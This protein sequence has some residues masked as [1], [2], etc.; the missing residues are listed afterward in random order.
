[1]MVLRQLNLIPDKEFSRHKELDIYMQVWQAPGKIANI[2]AI[3]SYLKNQNIPGEIIE[4]QSISEKLIKSQP[5]L[6][7]KYENEIKP[8]KISAFKVDILGDTDHLIFFVANSRM[9]LHA[10]IIRRNQYKYTLTDPDTLKTIEGPSLSDLLQ[11]VRKLEPSY[12]YTGISI[13]ISAQ[14]R[15]EQILSQSAS[16]TLFS[17]SAQDTTEQNAPAKIIKPESNTP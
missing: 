14:V 10:L 3:L 11:S 8:Q 6:K 1:M 7:Q 12:I 13:K 4:D 16:Q 5:T 17:S 15:P 9:N 2:Q